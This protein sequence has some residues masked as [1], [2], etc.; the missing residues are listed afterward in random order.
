MLS[1]EVLTMGVFFEVGEFP[2]QYGHARKPGYRIARR[3]PSRS[4]RCKDVITK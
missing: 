3:H 1:A 2:P 4:L